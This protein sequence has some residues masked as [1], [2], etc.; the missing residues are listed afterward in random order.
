MKSDVILSNFDVFREGSKLQGGHDVR[1]RSQCTVPDFLCTVWY[2][3]FLVCMVCTV[4][5]RVF[6]KNLKTNILEENKIEKK[7]VWRIGFS[8]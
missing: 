5:F 8:F 3:I 2:D 7:N 4:F 6:K 1:Y